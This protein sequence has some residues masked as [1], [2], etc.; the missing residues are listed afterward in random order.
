MPVDLNTL[1]PPGSGLQLQLTEG[2]NDFGKMSDSR[3]RPAPA[4]PTDSVDAALARNQRLPKLSPGTITRV[5]LPDVGGKARLSCK[6][7]PLFS[8]GT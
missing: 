1:M 3:C 2:L 8:G 7:S 6:R 5:G 4:Q